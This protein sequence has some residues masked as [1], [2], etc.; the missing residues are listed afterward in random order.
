MCTRDLSKH[1]FVYKNH[2]NKKSLY[3]TPNYFYIIIH[4]PFHF[5]FFLAINS[6]P[7]I[8]F[9]LVLTV[10]IDLLIILAISSCL[11]IGLLLIIF[12]LACTL[13]IHHPK[14][15]KNLD[16]TIY[17]FYFK[18]LLIKL[19]SFFGDF[20]PHLFYTSIITFFHLLVKPT[21]VNI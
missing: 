7:C 15:K 11:I 19:Y 8:S 2:Y 21:S 13:K 9:I 14:I 20:S 16:F 18:I 1:Q 6:F 3:L 12:I 4:S 5:P 10:L 17:S